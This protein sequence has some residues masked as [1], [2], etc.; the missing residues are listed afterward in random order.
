MNSRTLI[1]EPHPC[2]RAL[3]QMN[4]IPSPRDFLKNNYTFIHLLTLASLQIVVQSIYLSG[5]TS[6]FQTHSTPFL[7]IQGVVALSAQG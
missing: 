7:I 6:T 3:Y 2:V 1:S 5:C 4:Y